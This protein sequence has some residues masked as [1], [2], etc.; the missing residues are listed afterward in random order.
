[1]LGLSPQLFSN[2]TEDIS[3]QL[4]D[5]GVVRKQLVDGIKNYREVSN[6][7]TAGYSSRV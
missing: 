7:P 4:E 2:Y 6:S 3:N 5:L 1:M